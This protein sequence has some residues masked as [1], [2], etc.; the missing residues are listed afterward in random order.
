VN[1]SGAVETLFHTA[2]DIIEKAAIRYA[3]VGALARNA[4][5]R[6]R[7]T[8]DVDFAVMLDA[9]EVER[10]QTGFFDAGFVVRKVRKGEEG[11]PVPELLLLASV[12]DAALRV[13]LLIAKT[14]FEMEAIGRCRLA[15]VFGRSC[16]VVTPEDLVVYKVVSGRS[17]D[18]ADVENVARTRSE[19]GEPIDWTYVE[20]WAAE[21]GVEARLQDIRSRVGV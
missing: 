21:F 16:H 6:P 20:R 1:A 7:T 17:Q 10:L 3:V 15:T 9:G 18:L 13:D 19:A 2:V 4:W 11:D 12:S 8:M 5:G 14:P